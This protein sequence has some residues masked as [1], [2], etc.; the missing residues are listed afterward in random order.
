MRKGV[1][2]IV[3]LAWAGLSWATCEEG[4][5]PYPQ[6]GG[7]AYGAVAAC[8]GVAPQWISGRVDQVRVVGGSAKDSTA[9]KQADGR[10]WT[11]A[12][13]AVRSAVLPSDFSDWG[14]ADETGWTVAHE[15]ATAGH[16]PLGFAHWALA[17]QEGW[18]VAHAAA[19]SGRLPTRF[20]QWGLTDQWG[21]SVRSV[22][23]NA[24]ALAA[25][26]E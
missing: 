26:R 18:T 20:T 13:E 6:T 21:R 14:L 15:A 11:A 24:P 9:W 2:I 25:Q 7:R 5:C 8:G 23:V 17:N 1:W 3:G 16:L 22:L 12:H 19:A 10:G 4:G